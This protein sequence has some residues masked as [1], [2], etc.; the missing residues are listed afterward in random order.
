MRREQEL[1]ESQKPNK[2]CG[3]GLVSTK[4]QFLHIET[5]I[6]YVE[7]VEKFFLLSQL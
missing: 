5:V 3:V 6:T 4:D 7:T 2:T 1:E